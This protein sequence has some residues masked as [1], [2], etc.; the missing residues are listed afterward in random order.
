MIFG[1]CFIYLLWQDVAQR[2][3]GK[4]R[5]E[6]T[7]L[8]CSL[9]PMSVPQHHPQVCLSCSFHD[10]AQAVRSTGDCLHPYPSDP[11]KIFH[12]WSLI[13]G[14]WSSAGIIT[15]MKMGP[16]RLPCSD[17]YLSTVNR[18]ERHL[19]HWVL[20]IFPVWM[21]RVQVFFSHRIVGDRL[22]NEGTFIYLF[23]DWLRQECWGILIK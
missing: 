17:C 21:R 16:A 15:T 3:W 8:F 11:P 6:R 2:V 13:R 20:F 4:D 9:H 23:I 10:N 18:V 7:A 12:P 1:W 22:K 19:N 5:K 14:S